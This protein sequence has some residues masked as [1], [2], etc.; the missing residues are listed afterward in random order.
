MQYSMLHLLQIWEYP[1]LSM[2]TMHAELNTAG[3][4]VGD[5]IFFKN[6]IKI[7]YI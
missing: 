4:I 1:N 6:M 2:K 3:K 7:Y 5:L